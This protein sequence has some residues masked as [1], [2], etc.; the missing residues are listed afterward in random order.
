[1]MDCAEEGLSR[2]VTISTTFV[3]AAFPLLDPAPR[4]FS[5]ESGENE[6]RTHV[7]VQPRGRPNWPT[8]TEG[9]VDFEWEPGYLDPNIPSCTDQVRK[10]GHRVLNFR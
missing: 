10:K 4:D 9:W 5:K 2:G 1:M 7:D 3:S 8:Y 6:C